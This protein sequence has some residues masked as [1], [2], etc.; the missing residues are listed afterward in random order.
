M[1]YEIVTKDGITVR[2]IPDNVDPNS[3]ELKA[4][5]QR[6]RD[7]QAVTSDVEK[8]REG[9][10]IE[11]GFRGAGA[12]LQ[13]DYYGLKD[14]FTDL[15]PEEKRAVAANKKFLSEDTAGAVGG[16]GAD[17]ASFLLPGG[18]AAKV[19]TKALPMLPRAAKIYQGMSRG[20]QVA[21]N[22]AGQAALDA[23]LSAAYEPEDRTEAA[24]FGGAG[25][26]G[27][28][29]LG[30]TLGKLATGVIKPSADAAKLM[31][32]G[33]DVPVWKATENPYVRGTI[34]RAKALPL[35]GMVSK[36]RERSAVEAFNANL[37]EKA[38]PPLPVL[39]EAGNVL[40]WEMDKPVKDIGP[41]GIGA[42]QDRFNEAYGALYEG[43]GIPVDEV[44]GKEIATTVDEVKKYYPRISGEF[45][46]AVTQA[47]D[48]LRRGTDNHAVSSPESLK[49]SIDSLNK[50]ITEAWS[51]GEASLA[52]S[53]GAVRD[54]L[55]DLRV[56]ALP[57]EVASMAKP[58]NEAYATFKQMQKAATSPAVQRQE[59]IT[60]NQMLSAIKANDRTPG[61]SAFARGTAK[62]QDLAATSARVLG[63]ELPEVGP[64]T[65]EKGVLTYLLSNPAMFATD[66][67]MGMTLGAL[68]TKPGQKFLLGGYDKQK[69]L[70]DFL[71]RRNMPYAGATGAA[72]MNY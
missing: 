52:E 57:P 67:G 53:L 44:Y 39:D 15:S 20:G 38:T 35:T 50:R 48:L 54:S 71:R 41:K 5:V 64:G 14:L 7:E 24:V 55:T 30:R 45:E 58:I 16:F 34:E 27:G 4:R 59:V 69:A 62:N 11:R 43:R 56:R 72:L 46:A 28:Q 23:G 60:P 70:Q 32:Q 18:V 2:N 36:G 9:G 19:A 61:K 42:L 51:R 3:P 1:P 25:S 47:D 6:A 17:V 13:T 26:L 65:A 33:L 29:L 8:M 31:E 49:M 66:A 21:T 40:R 68:S 37:A 12:S 63:S 10:A 22:I